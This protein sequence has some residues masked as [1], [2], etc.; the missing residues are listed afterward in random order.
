MKVNAT[1]L[2]FATLKNWLIIQIFQNVSVKKFISIKKPIQKKKIKTVSKALFSYE[3]CIVI[4]HMCEETSATSSVAVQRW[5]SDENLWLITMLHKHLGSKLLIL[6]DLYKS[7]NWE[8]EFLSCG[9]LSNWKCLI[10]ILTA[11]N[12]HT[13]VIKHT[14]YW[15]HNDKLI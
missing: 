2:T 1:R 7:E 13:H 9:F 10:Y 5:P 3:Y 14:E 8:A 6:A 15:L 11:I 4:R 12:T